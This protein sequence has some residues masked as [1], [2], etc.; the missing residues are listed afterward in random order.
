MYTFFVYFYIYTFKYTKK[1]FN[2]LMLKFSIIQY[3]YYHSISIY[4]F[5]IKVLVTQSCPTLYDPMDYS[6]PDSSI[7]GILEA[8][9]LKW[10]AISFSRGYSWPRDWTQVSCIASRLF[11]KWATKEA[12]QYQK[13]VIKKL[14]FNEDYTTVVWI[15]GSNIS[16]PPPLYFPRAGQCW[17]IL[18]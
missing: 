10:V 6:P 4:S 7:H 1:V 9:I 16:C 18:L 2:H 17:I 3:Q 14:K 13:Q 5:N 12:S 15:N 8:R 11:T